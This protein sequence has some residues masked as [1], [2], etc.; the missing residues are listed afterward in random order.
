MH[1]N[2]LMPAIAI[3]ILMVIGLVYTIVEFTALGEDAVLRTKRIAKKI[4]PPH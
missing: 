2:I 4:R 3:F 1:H